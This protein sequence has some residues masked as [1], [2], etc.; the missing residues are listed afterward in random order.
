MDRIFMDSSFIIALTRESD[1]QHER[2]KELRQS[3]GKDTTFIISDHIL[4]EVV[5]FLSKRDNKDIAFKAGI[6]LLESSDMLVLY[7]DENDVKSSLGLLKK[8]DGISLCDSLS[9][10]MMGKHKIK[11]IL[12]FDSDFDRFP[13]IERVC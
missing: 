7:A 4:G 5:T 6:A 11:K 3:I 1:E 8:M 9:A 10:T 12:T 2:A 13:G